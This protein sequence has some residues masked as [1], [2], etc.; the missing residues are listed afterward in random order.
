MIEPLL[1]HVNEAISWSSSGN[2]IRLN[3]IRGVDNSKRAV[4][5]S[6]DDGSEGDGSEDD[7]SEDD[8]SED[9]ASDVLAV[10]REF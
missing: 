10:N 1:Q 4:S 7:W 5:S 2:D 3:P 9:D 8:E 6:E